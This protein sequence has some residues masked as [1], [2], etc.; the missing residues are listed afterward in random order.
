MSSSPSQATADDLPN[1]LLLLIYPLLPLPSLIA[2]R[3]V[4]KRWRLLVNEANLDP[5]R[6]NLLDLYLTAITSR[7]FL[8]SR[9]HIIPHLRPFDRDAYL[10]AI[11]PSI[12]LPPEFEVWVREWPER[13]VISWIWPGLDYNMYEGPSTPYRIRGVSNALGRIPPWVKTVSY[14]Q[15][16]NPDESQNGS[17]FLATTYLPAGINVSLAEDVSWLN[18]EDMVFSIEVTAICVRQLKCGDRHM[19]VLNGRRGGEKIQG[20]VYKGGMGMGPQD[21]ISGGWVEFLKQELRRAEEAVNTQ[22][23][24]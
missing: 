3:S 6:R 9:K 21:I 13:A 16:I 2:S 17:E 12:S 23:T 14:H 18:E 4:C 15:R 10:H 1:E 7:A 8:E 11:P 5:A 20:T 24:E 22:P 19:M